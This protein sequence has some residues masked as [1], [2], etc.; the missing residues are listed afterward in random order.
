MSLIQNMH[1]TDACAVGGLWGAAVMHWAAGEQLQGLEALLRA[2]GSPRG[3]WSGSSLAPSSSGDAHSSSEECELL[4][5][6]LRHGCRLPDVRL[7]R[8]KHPPA[9]SLHTCTVWLN[10]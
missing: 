4:I 6:F 9:H 7:W 10:E 2:A 3:S 5:D 1:V 8:G